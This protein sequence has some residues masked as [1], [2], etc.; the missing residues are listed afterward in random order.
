MNSLA[1]QHKAVLAWV[2]MSTMFVLGAL[3]A[4]DLPA[5]FDALSTWK[6]LPPFAAVAL[7]VLVPPLELFASSA[8]MAG[9]A[10]RKTAWLAILLVACFTGAYLWQLIFHG[11]PHCGCG[12]PV[13]GIAM[14]SPVAVLGRNAAILFCLTGALL[15]SP[16]SSSLSSLSVCSSPS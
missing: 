2:G 5:F 14:D 8:W 13:S 16:R 4:S 9:V 10:R 12:G 11:R 6:G 15:H 3:K 7:V 1:P